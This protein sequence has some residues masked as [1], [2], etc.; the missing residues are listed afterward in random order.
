MES[1]NLSRACF[2]NNKNK[3]DEIIK[4]FIKE[5]VK[6]TLSFALYECVNFRRYEMFKYICDT[7]TNNIK[8]EGSN[9]Y[10]SFIFLTSFEIFKYYVDSVGTSFITESFDYKKSINESLK[11][12]RFRGM[13]KKNFKNYTYLL[14]LGVADIFYDAW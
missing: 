1:K 14:S 12:I 7:Y 8:Q 2:E 3:V 13:Y 4:I 11:F 5:E 6:L 10:N 9:Y